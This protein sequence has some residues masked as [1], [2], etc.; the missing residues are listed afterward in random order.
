MY[1][2]KSLNQ[3]LQDQEKDYQQLFE[4]Q[5]YAQFKQK[6]WCQSMAFTKGNQLLIIQCKTFIKVLS[7]LQGQI[8][9]IKILS[10]HK[11]YLTT[12]TILQKI[13]L[14]ISTSQEGY[15]HIWSLIPIAKPIIIKKF[16]TTSSYVSCLIN[17][18]SCDL[19]ITGNNNIINFW[20]NPM[21]WFLIQS[22]NDHAGAVWALSLNQNENKLI[23]CGWDKM[24][25]IIVKQSDENWIVTQ[26]VFVQQYGYRICF[27]DNDQFLYQPRYKKAIILYQILDNGCQVEKVKEIELTQTSK[28][29]NAFFPMQFEKQKKIILNKNGDTIIILKVIGQGQIQIMQFI[30]FE[31]YNIFGKMSEDGQLLA[32]W[33]ESKKNLQIRKLQYYSLE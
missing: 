6:D 19:I 24:I 8:N 29:C 13:N 5:L 21:K 27:L 2:E 3:K 31:S 23:S 22:I 30:Y 10:S 1:R 16:D 25:L 15:I 9:Q 17:N 4:Y 18:E 12:I 33:D 32:I 20:K 11:T 26:K 14:L 7:I 28:D